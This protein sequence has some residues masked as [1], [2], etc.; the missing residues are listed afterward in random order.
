MDHTTSVAIVEISASNTANLQ[1]WG[2]KDG[3]TGGL[4]I[5]QDVRPDILGS[6]ALLQIWPQ[7]RPE[8]HGSSLPHYHG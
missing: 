1:A 8:H 4:G 3:R 7:G 2:D 5:A 6:L